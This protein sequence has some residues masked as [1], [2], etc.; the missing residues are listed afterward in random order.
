MDAVPGML[1][2]LLML[3]APVAAPGGS[4]HPGVLHPGPPVNV[5][6]SIEEERIAILVQAEQATANPWVGVLPD[7]LLPAPLP[8]DKVA[9]Y[10]LGA[11]EFFERANP[12]TVDGVRVIPILNEVQLVESF[13]GLNDPPILQFDLEIPRD[14]WP[15]SVGIVWEEWERTEGV[16]GKRIPLL[17]RWPIGE[18]QFASLRPEEP[19]FVWHALPGL[20]EKRSAPAA[21]AAPPE[22]DL[23]LP[24]VLIG[25]GLLL[26][27]PL[28]RRL[29][30]PLWLGLG[31]WVAGLG[32][33]WTLR[34]TRVQSPWSRVPIPEREEA[35]AM[36]ESLHSNIYQAFASRDEEN[37]YEL[38]SRSVAPDILDELYGEVFESMILRG[39]GGAICDVQKLEVLER[40]VAL[41]ESSSGEEAPAFEIDWRW[42]VK[43]L[44]SHYNHRHERINLY[45]A[46]YRVAHDGASWK[47]ADVEILDHKRLGE[48]GGG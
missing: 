42:S 6:I 16:E 2:L 12:L 19:E 28:L 24:S 13:A 35:L 40:D 3:H 14:D 46:R 5:E 39:E 43:G 38:L 34:T 48:L 10:E 20:G 18:F 32:A 23:P 47:I 29:R 4:P 8:E 30:P 9:S 22:P 26:S 36:F 37:V 33:A 15:R 25:A 27:I 45:H 11:R 17:V 44:V 31:L 21:P 1:A 7:R 41:P